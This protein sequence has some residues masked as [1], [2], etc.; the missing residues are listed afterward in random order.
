[1]SRFTILP[2]AKASSQPACACWD[3][4]E[5]GLSASLNAGVNRN[6]SFLSTSGF[7]RYRLKIVQLTGTGPTTVTLR[8]MSW[9]RTVADI[10]Q[11]VVAF[12][13]MAT[14]VRSV[15]D[16]GEGTANL[17]N[18]MGPYLI[19]NIANIG[20]DAATYEIELWAQS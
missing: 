9:N 18:H 6:S 2:A 5:M 13:A 3:A 15:Y 12:A 11:S 16:F 1:M 17:T 7:R 8:D 20:P 10:W 19:L 14:G 4:P